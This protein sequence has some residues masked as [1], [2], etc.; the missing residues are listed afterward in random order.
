[1]GSGGVLLSKRAKYGLKA[2]IRLAEV[3]PEGP[4]LIADLAKHERIPLKF[5][6][7]ILLRLKQA[8]Y[9]A[10]KKGRGGGYS[11]AMAPN[12]VMVGDVVRL[13]DGPLAL[14]PCASL[15]AYRPCSDC[16]DESACGIRSIMKEVR[17]VTAAILDRTSLGEL[18]A[19]E[20]RGQRSLAAE[21]SRGARPV[22]DRRKGGRSGSA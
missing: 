17:D 4:V 18:C 15:T 22:P 20:R 2:L 13:L 8:G 1:L 7:N 11:L 10:S 5:L 16:D 6:E 3:W 19:R 14:V 9:L 21:T 12:A